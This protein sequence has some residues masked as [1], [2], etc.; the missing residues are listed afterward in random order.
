MTEKTGQGRRAMTRDSRLF[1]FM[2]GL[3]M[4]AATRSSAQGTGELRLAPQVDERVELLSIVFRLAGNSEYNMN[5][6]GGYSADIDSYFAPYKSHPAVLLAKKVAENNDVGFDAV[7]SMAVHLTPAP[8]LSPVIPFTDQIPD[9]RWGKDNAVLFAQTLRAFYRDTNFEKFFRSHQPMYQVAESRFHVVLEALD[10]DW[11]KKFYGE[12][13]KG[14]FNVVLGLNNGGGNYGPKVIFPDGHQE[15]YAITGCWTKD[16]SGNPTFSSADYLPQLIHE[17]NHSFVNPVIEQNKGQFAPADQVYRLVANQMR[18]MAYGDSKVMVE[19]S[20]VRAA[21][22]LYFESGKSSADRIDRMIIKEQANGF[23]WMDELCDLLRRF[24]SQ[25]SRY[26]TFASFVPEIA[27]VYRSL[28]R[29][30]S[31]KIASFDRH[32]VHVTGMQPFPNHGTEVDPATKEVVITFDKALDPEGGPKHH[33]YSINLGQDGEEH[34]PIKGRP[35]FL[36]GNRS[37]KLP[38]E[39]KPGWTYSFVLTPL[40]FGS[41]VG[42]PLVSYTVAFSTK[43]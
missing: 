28:A 19:E 4:L 11:Y 30:I 5:Q 36:P 10:L 42:Y 43:K 7:M 21:V 17:F 8:G 33:G 2:L 27:E 20:L 32:C 18:E 37:I 22:I 16:D 23:V 34:F 12:V 6:L 9:P 39:L 40:A 29:R 35:E 13:P 24:E 31:E 1:S 25:R 41:P 26:P 14:H 3:L 38:V 15:L